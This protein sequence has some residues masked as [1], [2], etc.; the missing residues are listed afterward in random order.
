MCL[1]KLR[2]FE[3]EIGAGCDVDGLKNTFGFGAIDDLELS[4]VIA[5]NSTTKFGLLID[6]DAD[7]AGHISEIGDTVEATA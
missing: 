4:S 1:G 5:R 7:S 2:E 6:A 3:A